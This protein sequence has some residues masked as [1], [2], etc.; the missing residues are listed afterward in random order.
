[1]L[2]TLFRRRPGLPV[3]SIPKQAQPPLFK[4]KPPLWARWALVLVSLDVMVASVI[5]WN[6]D[7]IFTNSNTYISIALQ[8]S[9]SPGITGQ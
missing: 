5:P 4:I 1:M 2:A 8:R 3:V 6:L 9:N 7:V